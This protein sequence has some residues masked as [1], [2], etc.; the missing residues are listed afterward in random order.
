[1]SQAESVDQIEERAAIR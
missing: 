1:M